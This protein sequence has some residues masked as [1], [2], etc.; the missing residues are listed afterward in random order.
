MQHQTETHHD[1]EQKDAFGVALARLLTLLQWDN[2][3]MS[4][5]LIAALL[6]D[7]QAQPE[8]LSQASGPVVGLARWLLQA[9]VSGFALTASLGAGWARQVAWAAGMTGL[10]GCCS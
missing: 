3:P 2:A 7:L 8:F 1:A 4:E 6:H 5:E 10:A 9:D